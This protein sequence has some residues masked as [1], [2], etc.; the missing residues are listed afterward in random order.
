MT[1]SLLSLFLLFSIWVPCY[2]EWG[3]S[4]DWTG[5]D[6]TGLVL[7]LEQRHK[8]TTT[9]TDTWNDLSGLDISG[10]A[11][12]LQQATAGSRPTVV[13]GKH[14][15]RTF[16]GTADYMHQEVHDTNHAARQDLSIKHDNMRE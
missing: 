8:D 2:A 3:T 13:I 9:D 6:P 15:Y 1:K 4:G 11:N 10:Q 14:S 5:V 16:D 7:R 12:D